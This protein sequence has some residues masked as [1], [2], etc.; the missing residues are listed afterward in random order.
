MIV[1]MPLWFGIRDHRSTAPGKR[2]IAQAAPAKLG[3]R[4]SGP[5]EPDHLASGSAGTTISLILR[6]LPDTASRVS[7]LLAQ[8]AI[9]YLEMPLG[10]QEHPER[11]SPLCQSSGESQRRCKA[12][13]G[14]FGVNP[15]NR[16]SLSRGAMDDG[17]SNLMPY[18]KLNYDT[19]APE[20]VLDYQTSR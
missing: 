20:V 1:G 6:K 18:Q 9:F 8:R 17:L 7:R 2:I 13:S 19:M 12:V 16:S 10:T 14:S 3:H 15:R 4:P 11:H 5:W